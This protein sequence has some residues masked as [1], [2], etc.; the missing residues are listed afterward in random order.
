MA[1]P[2]PEGLNTGEGAS[3]RP[4]IRIREAYYVHQRTFL[5]FAASS[6]L[7]VL[8]SGARWSGRTLRSS[9]AAK[10]A[11]WLKSRGIFRDPDTN[12]FDLSTNEA[13]RLALAVSEV[14]VPTVLFIDE[15][16]SLANL[17]NRLPGCRLIS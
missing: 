15:I 16:S 17:Q 1:R 13:W 9:M 3:L 5:Q 10:V 7:G 11:D 4:R 2:A 6:V 14:V 8:A 12:P